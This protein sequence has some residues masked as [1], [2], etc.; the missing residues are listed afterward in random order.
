[1]GRQT[2]FCSLQCKNR[3][4][5]NRL[6]VYA[7]Q[8]ERGIKNK[9]KLVEGFGGRCIKC[10][11]D[12]NYA[13]LTFHHTRDKEF[14]LDLRHCSNRSWSKLTKEAEKCQLLCIRCHIELHHPEFKK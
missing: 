13:A 1:M 2:K 14:P 11:Y 10:G 4:T 6:Q 12:D 3:D 8:Q 7:A 9:T 5:N